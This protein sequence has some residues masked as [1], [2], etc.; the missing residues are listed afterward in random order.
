MRILIF[1]EEF[2]VFGR[3]FKFK[4]GLLAP[5]HVPSLSVPRP[6]RLVTF[7][8]EDWGADPILFVK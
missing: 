7:L 4:S 2:S 6:P 5:T 1:G 3:Y 8:G